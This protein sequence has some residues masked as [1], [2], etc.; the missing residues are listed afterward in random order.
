[1]NL[2][3][4]RTK[5]EE[6]KKSNG[7]VYRVAAQLNIFKLRMESLATMSSMSSEMLVFGLDLI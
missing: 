4:D 5:K 6:E 1:M 3:V 2:Y 7:L